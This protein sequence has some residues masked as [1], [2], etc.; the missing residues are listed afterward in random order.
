MTG[1]R[2]SRLTG[3]HTLPLGARDL[4]FRATAVTEVGALTAAAGVRCLRVGLGVRGSRNVGSVLAVL[5]VLRVR[6]R[7]PASV[8]PMPDRALHGRPIL[9]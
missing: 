4:I 5:R 8:R 7:H 2:T 9:S 1:R 6:V 3:V